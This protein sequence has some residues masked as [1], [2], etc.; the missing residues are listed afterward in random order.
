[1]Y[2][3]PVERLCI[4]S[5]HGTET[6]F[7]AWAFDMLRLG[8][9][10]SEFDATPPITLA[11]SLPAGAFAGPLIAAG[12]IVGRS[13]GPS[14][15]AGTGDDVDPEKVQLFRDLCALPQGTPV[16]LRKGNKAVRSVFDGIKVDYGR[17][18]AII[19]FQR[20]SKGSGR[21]LIDEAQVDRVLFA[22]ESRVSQVERQLG[23]ETSVDLGLARAF[24]SDDA[25]LRRHFFRL[26]ADCALIGRVNRLTGEIL[27][28]L[29]AYAYGGKVIDGTLQD[30]LRVSRF[31]PA[32]E[33]SRG[34]I[35][36]ENGEHRALKRYSPSLAVFC[37]A[38]AYINVSPSV[39]A[40]HHAALLTPTERHF[41]DALDALNHGFLSKLKEISSDGWRVP[42][43]VL[44]MAFRRRNP[45]KR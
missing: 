30:V 6:R 28:E 36:K 45:E 44:A 3:I 26:S 35:F 12:Y 17:E 40:A 7:G 31:L 9:S 20:E 21:E 33:S 18:W 41:N 32:M 4:R 43:G 15:S 37:T 19:R 22:R 8:Q 1:M 27:S 5:P 23:R 10:I 13:I 24:L 25:V 16:R 14:Q 42:N 38:S 34:K 2:D 39:P 29:R 11:L